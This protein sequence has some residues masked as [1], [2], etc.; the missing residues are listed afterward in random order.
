[1]PQSPPAAPP[2]STLMRLY[3]LL[4]VFLVVPIALSYGVAPAMTLP[5]ALDI[6]VSGTDL[7]HIFRALM[8]LYLGA[9]AF[10][11]IAAFRPAWQRM[12]VIWAVFFAFSL[13]AGRVISLVVDGRPSLL[14]IVYLCLEIFGGLLGLAVLAAADRR[15]KQ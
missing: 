7:T 1:M 9:A 11:A 8:C 15:L 12:A 4:F 13:A 14:L 10:W 3:L 2:S 5:Q 6:T